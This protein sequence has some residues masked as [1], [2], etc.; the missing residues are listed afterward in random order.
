M[1]ELLH[2]EVNG[3]PAACCAMRSS[4]ASS[5]GRADAAAL[6][7]ARAISRVARRAMGRSSTRT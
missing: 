6:K 4:V 1:S 5:T 2:L 3:E 7:T